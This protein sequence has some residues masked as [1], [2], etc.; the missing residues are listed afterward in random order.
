[1]RLMKK[2]LNYSNLIKQLETML[3]IEE[4][5]QH[6]KYDLGMSDI[7]IEGYFEMYIDTYID[8]RGLVDENC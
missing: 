5:T 7:E 4:E 8:I 6:L 3:A 2:N 1:M